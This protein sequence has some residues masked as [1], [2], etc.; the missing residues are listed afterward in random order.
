MTLNIQAQ[1]E[2]ITADLPEFEQVLASINTS[3]ENMITSLESS[4]LSTQNKV[5]ETIDAI[6]IN[7]HQQTSDLPFLFGDELEE[8]CNSL[9]SELDVIKSQAESVANA[10]DKL[11]ANSENFVDK[12]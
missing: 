4:V 8:S 6:E 3:F 11:V 10:L 9:E 7:F 1:I 2:Q 12:V 5:Q